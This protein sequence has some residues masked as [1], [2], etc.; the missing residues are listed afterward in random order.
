MLQA[1][2]ASDHPLM[3]CVARPKKH[4]GSTLHGELSTLMYGGYV[5]KHHVRAYNMH[6]HTVCSHTRLVRSRSSG[7][8]VPKVAVP[9]RSSRDG[10][11]SRPGSTE[12]RDD[13][14]WI[15]YGGFT[16]VA[17]PGDQQL[18]CVSLVAPGVN[19]HNSTS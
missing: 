12:D 11:F 15:I 3:L 4:L 6:R 2:K 19:K 10:K 18:L 7:D 9:I 8:K 16:R 13:Y 5:R 1:A 14:R 17:G